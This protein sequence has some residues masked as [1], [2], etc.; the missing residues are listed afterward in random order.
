MTLTD[1]TAY[2]TGMEMRLKERNE[3]YSNS[4][5]LATQLFMLRNVL[6]SMQF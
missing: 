4:K 6:N 1:F 3:K 2:I 5:Q